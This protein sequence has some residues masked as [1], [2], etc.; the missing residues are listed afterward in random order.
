MEFFAN[1]VNGNYLRNVLP[2]ASESIDWVRAAVA[3]GSD[4]N[5]LLKDCLEN[6]RRLDIWMRYDHTVPVK[7]DLLRALLDNTRNNIFCYL[8]PDVLHSKLIWWKNYGI[9]V[10]SANL[11]DRAWVSNIE[12]GVFISEVELENNGGLGQ[13]EN[14]FEFLLSCSE[15]RPLTLELVREQERLSALR[16]A[17]VNSLDEE[18]R[19]QRSI[20]LWEGPTFAANARKA[21]D[22]RR[23]KFIKEWSNGLTI[24]RSLADRAPEFRPRWLQEDVPAAWQADQFLHA[25]Y[26]NE[27]IDGVRHPYEEHYQKNSQ[28]P[29]GATLQA[30]RWWSQLDAPPS[31]EDHNCHYR[32]PIIRTIL[33]PENIQ[34]ISCADFEKVCHANHSTVDHVSRMP[35]A[36][37]GLEQQPGAPLEERVEAFAKWIWE[38]RNSM[39]ERITDLLAWVLDGGPPEELPARLFNAAQVEAR[40]FPH[41]GTNQIAEITGWARPNI[42]PPRNGRTSKALRALGYDVNVY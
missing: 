11:T 35:L 19:K 8:V 23:E 28:N 26:Y 31:Q 24:L 21:F 6:K 4:Q 14:F 32:A 5:T 29:A 41:F 20:G 16:A 7:P 33:A 2:G 36:A 30:F 1:K 34:G 27:V 12:F 13:V 39:G 9:Y 22:E 3:Y 38:K 40:R 10:G 37:I 15:V 25:Y 17:K 42:C 18:A